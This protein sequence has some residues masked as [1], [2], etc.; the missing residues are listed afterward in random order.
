VSTIKLYSP[1]DVMD[2]VEEFFSSGNHWAYKYGDPTPSCN[3]DSPY[4]RKQIEVIFENR[5]SHWDVNNAVDK[6]VSRGFLKL[7]TF[8]RAHFVFRSGIRYYIRKVKRRHEIIETYSQSTITAALGKWGEKLVEYMFRLNRFE[9]V[10]RNTN[11]FQGKKWTKTN[12]DLDFIVG[13]D[14]IAYGVEVKNT[15]PYMEADEFLSKLE[16]CKFL[17]L[18]P[19]WILRN[20]PEVQFNTMKA[21][22][23]FILFFKSQMYPYGQEPLVK[24]IWSKMRLPVA[25]RAEMPQKNVNSLMWFHDSILSP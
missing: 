12:E 7:V 8:G 11:E 13:R 10:G 3:P 14:Y 22:S 17:G 5:Y 19:L 2:D 1:K 25:V 9:I 18:V 4:H 15:L 21:N 16:M 23:G 24:E 20:A 6:F